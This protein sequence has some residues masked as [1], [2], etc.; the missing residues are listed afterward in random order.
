M[1]KYETVKQALG[2]RYAQ[3]NMSATSFESTK[4]LYL[5]K[6]LIFSLT[7]HVSRFHIFAQI[8]GAML[9]CAREYFIECI[10]VLPSRNQEK[11]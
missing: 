7:R 1:Y 10:N 9:T 2:D 5:M 11:L 8:S 4:S 3:M 6:C